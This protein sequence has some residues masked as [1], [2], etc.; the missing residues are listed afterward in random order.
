MGGASLVSGGE[1]Q[2]RG[3]EGRGSHKAA[4]RCGRF[5]A[6]LLFW[7]GEAGQCHKGVES[8]GAWG[9]VC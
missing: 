7:K 3:G 1:L 5:Q 4:G 9:T 8:S 6:E 2:Q